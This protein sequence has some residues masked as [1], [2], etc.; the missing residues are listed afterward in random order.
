MNSNKILNEDHIKAITNL[1]NHSPYFKHLSMQV[2]ELTF[3]YC[4]IEVELQTNHL[5]PFGGIHG[6]VYASAIDSAA[7]WAIY[8]DLNEDVGLISVDLKVDNLATLKD[9]KIII[10]GKKIKVGKTLCLSEA[11]A[12]DKYGKLLAHGTSKLMITPG[13]QSIKQALTNLGYNTFP[14]KFKSG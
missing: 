10:E 14:Q 3:G 1:I 5:N 7:Y 12:T 9:G 2:T 8:C 6:G 11:I 13:I 4:K